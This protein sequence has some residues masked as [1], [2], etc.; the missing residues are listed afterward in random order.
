[1]DEVF[2]AIA[3]ELKNT[4]LLAF[5]PDPGAGEWRSLRVAVKDQPSLKI[6]SRE[7]YFAE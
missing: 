3:D 7:G 1:M 6:R 4:Y 5:R 2:T